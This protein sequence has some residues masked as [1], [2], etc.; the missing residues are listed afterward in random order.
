MLISEANIR[1]F[2]SHQDAA[3]TET[4]ASGLTSDKTQVVS[5]VE[6]SGKPADKAVVGWPPADRIR[7]NPQESVPKTHTHTDMDVFGF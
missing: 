1:R 5:D 6:D 3:S 4:P 7:V 2:F